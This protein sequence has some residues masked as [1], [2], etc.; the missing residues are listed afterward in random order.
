MGKPLPEA[1][2]ELDAAQRKSPFNFNKLQAVTCILVSA[3]ISIALIVWAI[4]ALL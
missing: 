3:L 2:V 4:N 1:V